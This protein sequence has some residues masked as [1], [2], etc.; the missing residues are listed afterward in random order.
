MEEINVFGTID[1]DTVEEDNR[2]REGKTQGRDLI[3]CDNAHFKC[4]LK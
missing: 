3:T 2:N 4:G 1:S